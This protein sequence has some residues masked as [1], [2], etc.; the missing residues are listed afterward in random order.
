MTAF[1]S[2][3]GDHERVRVLVTALRRHGLRTWQYEDDLGQ[4]AATEHDIDAALGQCSSAM[5]W[6]GGDTMDSTF[7]TIVELPKIFQQHSDRGMRI[8]PLFVDTDVT[9][10]ADAVRAATGHEIASHNGYLW[11][12]SLTEPENLQRVA[13]RELVAE[14]TARAAA[15]GRPVVRM[16]TRSDGAGAR[17]T[18]DLNLDWIREYP[19]SGELPDVA[20]TLD[21]RAALHTATQALIAVY[22]AGDVELNLKCH[23][24]LG[25]AL[26]FE[27]RRTTGL[28]PT[29]E[30][31]GQWHRVSAVPPLPADAQLRE[32]TSDGPV[33]ATRAAVELS[34][35]RDVHPLVNAHIASTGTIYRCRIRFEPQ[36]GPGQQA[37]TGD[38]LNAWAEQAAEAIRGARRQPGVAGVDLF[39][40]CPIGFAVA[41]GW[42]LNALGGVVLYHPMENAGPYEAVWELQAS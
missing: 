39:V 13:H 3:S 8:V 25:L 28:T 11:N 1:I 14:L 37:V 19:S 4:G 23:L 33:G 32:I 26:G 21:L 29:V 35:T 17:D 2:Y 16:V 31:D 6:L 42:R 36:G 30:V 9:A 34:I 22:G 38:N 12:P 15:G 10:G 27:H 5:V 7:V 24:H 18:A 41:L 20:T 40:A